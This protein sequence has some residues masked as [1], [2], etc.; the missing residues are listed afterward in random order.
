MPERLLH[1]G[2]TARKS[3]GNAVLSLGHGNWQEAG[4]HPKNS[5]EMHLLIIVHWRLRNGLNRFN[6]LTASCRKIGIVF[7]SGIRVVRLMSLN[8]F[9]VE[10]FND[11]HSVNSMLGETID[12]NS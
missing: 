1:H 2:T 3:L 4:L 8:G 10:S 7:L 6:R 12:K 9:Q 5:D 11:C